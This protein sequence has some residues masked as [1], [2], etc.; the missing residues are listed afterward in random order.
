M[1]SPGSILFFGCGNQ[2]RRCFPDSER[3]DW[4]AGGFSEAR[5][6]VTQASVPW[7]RIVEVAADIPWCMAT[8]RRVGAI[9]CGSA[10]PGATTV[11]AH[12][13]VAIVAPRRRESR[14][15]DA[16]LPRARAVTHPIIEYCGSWATPVRY[17]V[18]V[19][20]G[21]CPPNRRPASAP[22]TRHRLTAEITWT[23]IR[24][25]ACFFRPHERAKRS[26]SFGRM[27]RADTAASTLSA[28]PRAIATRRKLSRVDDAPDSSR[29]SV[30]SPIPASSEKAFC[31]TLR[32]R[33]ILARRRPSSASKP[34]GVVVLHVS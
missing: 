22:S 32:A 2:I 13:P 9:S 21:R 30:R 34:C 3:F 14:L 8:F 27:S 20:C 16:S 19:R 24:R 25:A 28:R 7:W 1:S 23:T 5:S 12:A 10:V 15:D 4:S 6:M 18:F 29:R 26:T 33:R 17:G 11:A 31:V